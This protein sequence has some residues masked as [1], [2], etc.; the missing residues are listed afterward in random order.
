MA[1]GQRL[2]GEVMQGQKAKFWLFKIGTSQLR[3]TTLTENIGPP[4]QQK[5]GR[6]ADNPTLEKTLV[7]NLK[8]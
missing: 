3:E 1:P 5:D 6:G 4:G 7:T 2:Y 8:K